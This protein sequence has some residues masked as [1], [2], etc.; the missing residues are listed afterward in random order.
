MD[1]PFTLNIYLKGGPIGVTDWSIASATDN[2]S[3]EWRRLEGTFTPT[4]TGQFDEVGF[5][6]KGGAGVAFIDCIR[7]EATV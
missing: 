4:A 2:G 6:N 7:I 1:A 5:Q 3:G